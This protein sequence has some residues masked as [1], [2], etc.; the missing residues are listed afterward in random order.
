MPASSAIHQSETEELVS[1]ARSLGFYKVAEKLLGQ[2]E[3]DE[4]D[5]DNEDE[6]E[7][8]ILPSQRS[9]GAVYRT[10]RTMGCDMDC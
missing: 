3:D 1:L 4:D 9:F 8:E 2:D 10:L 7:G 6:S 5:L